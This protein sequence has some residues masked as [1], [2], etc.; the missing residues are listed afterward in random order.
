MKFRESF[1]CARFSKKKISLAE[2]QNFLKQFLEMMDEL[3]DYM[4]R[5]DCLW[6]E[7][8]YI[9]LKNA[10]Y[11]EFCYF[12]AAPMSIQEQFHKLTDYFVEQIDY[13][14]V[15]CIMLAHKLNRGT[16]EEQC[17]IADLMRE[18]E[19]EADER[20]RQE[21]RPIREDCFSMAEPEN[22]ARRGYKTEYPSG[23]EKGIES[24]KIKEDMDEE[25]K[26]WRWFQKRSAGERRKSFS[27][28]PHMFIRKKWG[29]WQDLLL[30]S[31]NDSEWCSAASEEE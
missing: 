13:A 27:A 23:M 4:L 9:Y 16:L 31:E 26:K 12:P 21:R 1:P 5:P 11:Y 7:P 18:Y 28:I 24:E 29:K 22:E 30:E 14:D 8:E 6:L 15:E 10:S 20:H 19:K 3:Q 25:T 2:L 17:D